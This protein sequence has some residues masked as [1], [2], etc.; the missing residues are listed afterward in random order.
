MKIITTSDWH[1]GNM[2]HGN[3]RIDEH[4]HFFNWLLKTIDEQQPDALLVAGDIFDNG[5]PSNAAQAVYYNFLAKAYLKSPDLQ[6]I[7]TAGN[8]DSPSKLESPRDLL[9]IMNMHVR[10]NIK[11]FWTIDKDNH[12]K[13]IIDYNDLI[14]PIKNKKNEEV[15][16]LAVPYLR[17]DIT[18]SENYSSGVNKFLRE[19]NDQARKLHPNKPIIMMAHMYAKGA[20]IATQDASE[21]IVIGGLEEVDM[22]NW[23]NHPDY[24][25]CGHIHKRQ[26][27]W[28]TKWARYTGSILP[29]SFAEENYSHGVDCITINNNSIVSTENITYQPQHKLRILP[30]NDEEL[31]FKEL[32]KLIN[33]E[34]KPRD[35]EHF[36]DT[37]DYITIKIRTDI[38]NKN[39]IK[40]LED[41]IKTKNAI[42]C[43]IQKIN[44]TIN[45][46][47]IRDNIQIKSI[48]DIINRNPLE[49]LKEAYLI[50]HKTEMNEQ[51]IDMLQNIINS[52]NINENE[53]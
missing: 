36:H 25:T 22:S 37:F 23:E 40:K 4:K 13:R 33:S 49:T 8:H 18:Q 38:V 9:S 48:D 43:K 2:F 52:I 5:N 41:L 42:L 19:L 24:L 39:E 16:I 14:I 27:I 47:T 32:E 34:L 45:L 21:K 28:G 46:A 1:I 6:I 44:P 51:Q 17:N 35:E 50:K 11:R 20:D 30:K 53:N 10:G 26:H 29:M 15:V 12:E 3:D 31:S 7:I